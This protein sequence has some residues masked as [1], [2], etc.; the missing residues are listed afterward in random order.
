MSTSATTTTACAE[1]T[2]AASSTHMQGQGDPAARLEQWRLR[3]RRRPGAARALPGAWPFRL[4]PR[5]ATSSGRPRERSIRQYRPRG[6]V[7]TVARVELPVGLAFDANGTL[8]IADGAANGVRRIGATARARRS[9]SRAPGRPCLRPARQPFRRPGGR[10][11]RSPDRPARHD[12]DRRRNRP[13]RV[14]GRRRPRGEGGAQP[15]RRTCLRREGQ[16]LHRRPRQRLDSHGGRH[17]VIT[18]F[19]DGRSS[20]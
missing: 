20:T 18:T 14:I 15:A 11:R 17:G 10:E 4:R 13:R 7:T 3:R 19:F 1:S 6:K 8:Y 9:R 16:P 5:M 2:R 12:H